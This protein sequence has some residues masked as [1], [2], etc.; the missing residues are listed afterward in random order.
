MAGGLTYAEVS[1]KAMAAPKDTKLAEQK[2]TLF[3]GE[4]LRGLL[5]S[6]WGWSVV[7]T[8]ATIAGIVLFLLGLILAGCPSPTSFVNE[9]HRPRRRSDSAP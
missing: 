4:T 8:I 2:A 6:V 1:S 3:Q 5:L 7:G 9:R